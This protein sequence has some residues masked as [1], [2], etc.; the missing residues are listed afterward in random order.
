MRRRTT[1]NAIIRAHQALDL[2]FTE[3]ATRILEDAAAHETAPVSRSQLLV[4][5]TAAY[6]LAGDEYLDLADAALDLAGSIRPDSRTE[7]LSRALHAELTVLYGHGTVKV[8]TLARAL[9]A[10][11]DSRACFHAASALLLADHP[12]AALRLLR[13][14]Q[15]PANLPPHLEWRS[16]SLAGV[17]LEQLG[18]FK[19]AARAIRQAVAGAPH[20]ELQELERLALADCLLELGDAQ[21]AATELAVINQEQLLRDEDHV[22]RH[23]LQA[24]AEF[25]LGNPGLAIQ[26]YRQARER[27]SPGHLIPAGVPWDEY[28]LLAAEAQLLADRGAYAESI[29]LYRQACQAAAPD[30]LPLTRHELAVVLIESGDT[31][32]AAQELTGLMQDHDYE[33]RA[34][35]IAELADLAFRNGDNQRAEQLALEAIAV[36]PVPAAYLCLG[37]IA[38]EYFRLDEAVSWFEKAA[39]ESLD[40]EPAWVAAQQ[41]LADTYSQMGPESAD[42]LYL[43]AQLALKYTDQRNDWYLPLRSHAESAE[44]ALAGQRRLVN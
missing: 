30:Q 5:L 11:G 25:E 44:R 21:S 26:H 10:E 39:A 16:W 15:D 34:E 19:L 23:W 1:S 28:G 17:A 24:R 12:E 14:A 18:D 8:R 32:A 6:L 41:L 20:G 9:R 40:G 4:E 36:R 22:Y 27:L 7:P 2:G 13:R 42:R 29:L 37:S 35:V 38:F 33:W 31:E 43:H 3:Q